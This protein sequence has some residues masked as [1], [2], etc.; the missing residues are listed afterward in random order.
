MWL[1]MRWLVIGERRRLTHWRL[2]PRLRVRLRPTSTWRT[3][4]VVLIDIVAHAQ[5]FGGVCFPG[6]DG[7]FVHRIVP[8][9][10]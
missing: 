9:Y 3:T 6:P 10:R 7:T 4:S 8:F 1:V 2:A 5:Q